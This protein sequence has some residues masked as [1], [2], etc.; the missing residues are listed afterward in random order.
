MTKILYVCLSNIKKVQYKTQIE[1]IIRSFL[2]IK[3]FFN[4]WLSQF[5]VE[6]AVNA[7]LKLMSQWS[8]NKSKYKACYRSQ[9][10]SWQKNTKT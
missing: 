1:Q 4:K 2:D 5:R 3:V 6:S 7:D 9:F 10:N 8:R